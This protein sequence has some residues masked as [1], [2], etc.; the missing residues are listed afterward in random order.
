MADRAHG[1]EDAVQRLRGQVQV[2]Q[3]RTGVPTR[4]E[5][6][7]RADEALQLAPEGAG[8]AATERD[9]KKSAAVYASSA[10]AAPPP[11]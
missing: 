10:T 8:A 11:S 9:G 7:F 5:P 6:D 3:A 2:G 1:P 4:G